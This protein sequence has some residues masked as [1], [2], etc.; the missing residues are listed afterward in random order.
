MVR[1]YYLSEIPAMIHDS[2]RI[3]YNLFSVFPNLTGLFLNSFYNG[4]LVLNYHSTPSQKNNYYGDIQIFKKQV[5]YFSRHFKIIKTEEM[6]EKINR[7]IELNGIEMAITFD[8][9]FLD[10]YNAYL[11]LKKI[12]IPA[13]FFVIINFIEKGLP[14]KYFMKWQHIEEISSNELFSIGSHTVSHP[15]LDK[16]EDAE[17]EKELRESKKI[18]EEHVNRRIETI[19]YP[20][21]KYNTKVVE[22]AKKVGYKG[23]FTT[24]RKLNNINTNPYKLG[25]FVINP[26]SIIGRMRSFFI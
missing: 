13:T 16:L 23:G 21:G 18:I 12:S 19:A 10:N 2:K 11:Y 25:R 3:V 4:F 6:I 9:G 1:K 22:L 26:K 24:E 14:E 20:Y 17:I 7:K 5:R 8:D 15:F